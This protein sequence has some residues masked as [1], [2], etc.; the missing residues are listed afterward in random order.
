MF[1]IVRANDHI[2][3]T[4]KTDMDM[5]VHKLNLNHANLMKISE[6]LNTFSFELHKYLSRY[7]EDTNMVFSPFGIFT[8]FSALSFGAKGKTKKEMIDALRFR[9]K[10]RVLKFMKIWYKE[11]SRKDTQGAK[12]FVA[13]RAW[14]SDNTKTLARYKHNTKKYFNFRT[15]KINVE[16][17]EKSLKRI[18][19]WIAK[20]TRNMIPKLFPSGTINSLTRLVIANAV[21]FKGEWANKFNKDKTEENIFCLNNICDT[22]GS[23][24]GGNKQVK[25][26]FMVQKARLPMGFI[27]DAKI[28]EIPYAGGVLSM[29]FL[30]PNV[31]SNIKNLE[32]K[33]N[34]GMFKRN[35]KQ[36]NKHYCH[37][38]YP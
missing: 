14:I 38:L 28:L 13:N 33:M 5:D 1:N 29:Y 12:L 3:D 37:C 17:P 19:G 21:Y 25:V 32:N 23:G 9:D 2:S 8:T 15:K 4:T 6:N 27:G 11:I 30:M 26:N 18:N 36:S 22:N 35:V 24:N 31:N 34:P 20:K 16:N 10:V 7:T